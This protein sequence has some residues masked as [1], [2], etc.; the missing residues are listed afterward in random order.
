MKMRLLNEE[1]FIKVFLVYTL[2][3]IPAVMSV[4]LSIQIK[5]RFVEKWNII[6]VDKVEIH[7]LQE[8]NE[9]YFNLRLEFLEVIVDWLIQNLSTI[10]SQ[11]SILT[12]KSSSFNSSELFSLELN[13]DSFLYFIGNVLG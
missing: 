11:N 1:H 12:S 2:Y 3:Y 8:L 10:T 4:Y 6:T 7:S 5:C 9:D 13:I